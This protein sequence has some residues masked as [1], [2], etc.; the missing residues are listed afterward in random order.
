M[1]RACQVQYISLFCNNSAYTLINTGHPRW[2]ARPAVTEYQQTGV[3]FFTDQA[4]N[5]N[6]KGGILAD[7]MEMGKTSMLYVVGVDLLNIL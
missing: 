4:A 6:F 1:C 7:D 2:Y 3:N 5:P